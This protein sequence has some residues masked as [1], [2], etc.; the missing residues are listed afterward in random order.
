MKEKLQTI[1]WFI[2]RPNMYSQIWQLF[3]R[4]FILRNDR[5]KET[6]SVAWCEQNGVSEEDAFRKLFPNSTFTSLKNSFPNEFENATK[7]VRNSTFDMG[8]AGAL[9]LIYNITVATKSTLVLETGVSYGW[10]SLAFLLALKD[11]N[12]KLFSVD[13]PYPKMNN[14]DFVGLVVLPELKKFWTL[15]R[16]PDRIGIP[17]AIK[18]SREKFDIVHYDSDKSYSGRKWAYPI[19]WKALNNGGI[20]I[21]DDIQ[22][23]I[24]FREFC[25]ELQVQ[26]IIAES[27]GKYVGIIKK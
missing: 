5:Y 9:D 1:L 22:D 15:F 23:N 19:L 8:G 3:L 16:L 21:S 27:Q 10:S 17:K 26:P 20:F 7:K 13:M 4:R 14:E 6:E 25:D 18:S 12:G 24:A 11:N 2:R